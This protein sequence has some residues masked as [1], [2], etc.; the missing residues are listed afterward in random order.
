MWS[1]MAP[2]FCSQ[3]DGVRLRLKRSKVG[4]QREDMEDM[5]LHGRVTAGDGLFLFIRWDDDGGWTC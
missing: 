1:S 3:G 5:R 4:S 2:C